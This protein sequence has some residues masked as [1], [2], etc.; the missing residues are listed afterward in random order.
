MFLI[1]LV[2]HKSG[3][4]FHKVLKMSFIAI[5]AHSSKFFAEYDWIDVDKMYLLMLLMICLIDMC[6]SSLLYWIE[7]W[8][9][10]DPNDQYDP[11]ILK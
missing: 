7:V 3:F 10:I 11:I 1:Y 4:I 2:G 5:F 9:K 6:T 8:M